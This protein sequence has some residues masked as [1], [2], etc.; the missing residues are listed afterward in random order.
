MIGLVILT[1]HRIC[2]GCYE[3]TIFQEKPFLK[4]FLFCERRFER[5]NIVNFIVLGM[6]FNIFLFSLRTLRT[7]MLYRRVTDRQTD[8]TLIMYFDERNK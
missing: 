1:Q 6:Q 7:T 2:N 8:R 5:L 4:T 3:T